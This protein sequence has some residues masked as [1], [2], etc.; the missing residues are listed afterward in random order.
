MKLFRHYSGGHPS[1]YYLL[2]DDAGRWWEALPNAREMW[3]LK[4]Q[5]GMIIWRST[6]WGIDDMDSVERKIPKWLKDIGWMF[7]DP[8]GKKIIEQNTYLRTPYEI[9]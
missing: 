5:K 4:V 7:L 8:L 1:G 6:R 3:G 9:F 2:Q